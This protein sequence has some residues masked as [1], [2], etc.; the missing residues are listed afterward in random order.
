M[1][2]RLPRVTAADPLR[3]L[4]RAGWR[5]VRQTGSHRTLTRPGRLDAVFAFHDDDE[6]GSRM[7]ARI[8]KRTSLKAEDLQQP[9]LRQYL[10][11]AIK[12]IKQTTPKSKF[13]AAKSVVKGVSP[14][15][16]RPRP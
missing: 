6:I 11:A 13:A 4:S 7:L 2:P 16:R 3:A 14:T 10:R 9:Y 12:H 8:A 5:P 15:K 1:S